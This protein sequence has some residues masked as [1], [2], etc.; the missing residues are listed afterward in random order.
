MEG[1]PNGICLDAHWKYGI[2]L[3]ASLWVLCFVVAALATAWNKGLSCK[4]IKRDEQR[5]DVANS[6]WL[7]FV[8]ILGI[9]WLWSACDLDRS[10]TM[11]H[12]YAEVF[13][14]LACV[15]FIFFLTFLLEG[16]ELAF[17]FLS[18]KGRTTS[19]PTRHI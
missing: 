16:V 7:S 1:C 4:E 3:F 11:R 2:G 17:T 18:D 8:L 6:L 15:S 14:Y 10:Y 5:A 12:N 9:V 13:L 19:Q